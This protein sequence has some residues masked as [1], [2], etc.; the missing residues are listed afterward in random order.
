MTVASVFDM[1]FSPEST[2]EGVGLALAIGADMP[3]TAGC[4]G[5]DVIRDLADPGHVVIV[6][7][8][9]TRSEGETVLSS[10]V[11]DSKISRVAEL[12]GQAPTGFLGDVISK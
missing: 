7:R 3:A 2:E 10:Y 5:Y 1:H 4:T 11:Q 6:T 8:W 9:N 12:L